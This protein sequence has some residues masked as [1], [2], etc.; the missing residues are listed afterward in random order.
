MFGSLARVHPHPQQPLQ[1]VLVVSHH[2][3]SGFRVS[4][5]TEGRCVC[6]FGKKEPPHS[7]QPTPKPSHRVAERAAAFVV[8]SVGVGPHHQQIEH[9]LGLPRCNGLMKWRAA[10]FV[11]D[12]G[13]RTLRQEFF[14][15]GKIS[16][17]G[18]IMDGILHEPWKP[19]R[20]LRSQRHA[21]AG[22]VMQH[23]RH[24]PGGRAG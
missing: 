1:P 16:P 20:N 17:P 5:P 7:V 8:E 13:S 15:H 2:A 11:A 4:I 10:F 14:Q 9:H 21:G 12:V 19:R 22:I 6:S 23:R 24:F 3:P 18:S